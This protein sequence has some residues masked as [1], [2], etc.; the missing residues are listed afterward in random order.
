M[1]AKMDSH[2]DARSADGVGGVFGRSEIKTFFVNYLVTIL[3]VEGLIFFVCFINTL[4]GE[5]GIFPWKAFIFAS[6]TAPIAITFIFAIIVLTFNRYIFRAPDQQFATSSPLAESEDGR[7]YK[8]LNLT[9]RVPFLLSLLLLIVACWVGFNMDIIAAYMARAGESAVR[10]FVIAF[11]VILGVATIF[12]ILW[13]VLSYRLRMRRMT[14]QQRY[15]QDVMDRFGLVILDDNTVLDREGN[16]VLLS[17]GRGKN[18][19]DGSGDNQDIRLLP[20]FN[21]E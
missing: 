12:A 19:G 7:I 17:D 18:P 20:R 5:Q 21:R 6:F 16:Q 13:L 3:V 10:Y 11:S 8:F 2:Q 9:Q 1:N 4:A 15:R 14:S